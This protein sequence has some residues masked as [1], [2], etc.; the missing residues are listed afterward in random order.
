MYNNELCILSRNS[1]AILTGYRRSSRENKWP[2]AGQPG[3][4]LP[5]WRSLAGEPGGRAP[6]MRAPNLGAGK[7]NRSQKQGTSG[8]SPRSAP[9]MRMQLV[10][11]FSCRAQGSGAGM[12]PFTA[13]PGHPETILA[14]RNCCNGPLGRPYPGFL[15]SPFPRRPTMRGVRPPRWCMLASMSPSKP[16]EKKRMPT[17]INSTPSIK[18]G[19]RFWM[20][21]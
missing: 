7:Q 21:P 18:S 20:L 15:T 12:V 14:G 8:R 16:V 11:R 1:V 4:V 5:G 10:C 2:F 6:Q 13:T 17:M 9:G 3:K 19:R